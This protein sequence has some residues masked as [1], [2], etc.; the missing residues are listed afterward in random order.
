MFIIHEKLRH[1]LLVKDDDFVYYQAV[2]PP[3]DYSIY[4]GD[5]LV[6][7]ETRELAEEKAASLER[8]F[9]AFELSHSF[10]VLEIKPVVR[11]YIVD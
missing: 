3:Y 4:M 10:E 2:N 5:E 8:E 1:E 9:D 6:M 11:W 7:F